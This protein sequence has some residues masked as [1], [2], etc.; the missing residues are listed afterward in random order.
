M[1]GNVVKK[2]YL[3]FFGVILKTIYLLYT[4][5]IIWVK[6]GKNTLLEVYNNIKY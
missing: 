1:A 5:Y 4:K 2:I 6:T 3:V